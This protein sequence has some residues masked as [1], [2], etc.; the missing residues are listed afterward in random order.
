MTMK[1]RQLILTATVL[2]VL[3]P[4]SANMEIRFVESAPKDW[5]SL[6]N[7][8]ECVVEELTMEVDLSNTIGKLIFDT[9]S[10]GEGV[11]VFQ[12][13]EKREG[14]I[15]LASSKKV[16]DGENKLS[17]LVKNLSPGQSVSF[18]IDVDDTMTNSELGNIRVSDAE[19]AGGTVSLKISDTLDVTG[20][21][22]SNAE[23]SL[24]SPE[25]V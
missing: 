3:Q 24:P 14:E 10:A 18:T 13:F 22:D 21:F 15:A 9:T 12:P 25:C 19:I 1:I 5:F 4:V 16:L 20:S 8:S 2:C 17:V 11:E 23:I 6:T 7:N